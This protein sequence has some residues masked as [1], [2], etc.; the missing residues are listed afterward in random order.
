MR[1]SL[2]VLATALCLCPTPSRSAETSRYAWGSWIENPALLGDPR[3]GR[4]E[5]RVVEGGVALRN[6]AFNLDLYRTYNGA[7]LEEGDKREILNSISGPSARGAFRGEAGM[8]G[9]HVGRV[10]F[11]SNAYAGG[12]LSLPKDLIELMFFGN[13]FDRRYELLGSGSVTAYVAVGGAFGLPAGKVAGWEASAGLGARV[14]VGAMAAKVTESS[15]SILTEA[16]GLSATGRTAVRRT[17][18]DGDA[19]RPLTVAFDLGGRAVRGRWEVGVVLKDLGP[20]FSWPDVEEKVFTLDIDNWTAEMGDSGYATSDTT[21]D[22][23]TW[24]TPLPTRLECRAARSFRWGALSLRWEQGL[25]RWAGVTTTPRVA[26]GGSWETTSW[27]RPWLELSM[28]SPEGFGLGFGIALHPGP[29]RFHLAFT[30]FRIP[31]SRSEALGA[32]LA[33]GFGG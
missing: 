16:A 23:G 24:S 17:L 8:L 4:W 10:A 18:D 28:G 26:L 19:G 27:C 11:V 2:I 15:M 21:F 22:P 13:A 3:I 29:L 32:R 12:D 30:E 6:N 1:R 25:R 20:S 9:V 33:L 5:I 7:F 14:A 31:P